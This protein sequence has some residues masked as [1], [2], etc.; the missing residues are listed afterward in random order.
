LTKAL[1]AEFDKLAQ[2]TGGA[3]THVTSDLLSN[4][5][6]AVRSLVRLP[7][8]VQ[9]PGWIEGPERPQ[10]DEFLAAQNGL[11]HVP[12]FL[13]G[14]ARY[15][16]PHSPAYFNT[17]SLEFAFDPKAGEPEEWMKFLNSLW[18]DEPDSIFLLQ[19]WCGYVLTPDTSQQKILLMVGPPRAGKG[20]I[21]RVIEA[22]VGSR[23]VAQPS[24]AGLTKQFGLQ[25]LIG[26]TVAVI[27]DAKTSNRMDLAQAAEKLLRISG[28]DGVEVDVK[29]QPQ[30]T[31]RLPIR[32]MILMNDLPD[33]P[34]ASTA[35]ANR[36]VILRFTRSWLG[37]EDID[38]E[39]RLR[40][41]LPSILLWSLKGLDRLRKKGRFTQPGA[42]EMTREILAGL[43]APVRQFVEDCCEVGPEFSVSVRDLFQWYQEWHQK[44]LGTEYRGDVRQFGR[45]LLAAVPTLGPAKQRK[46][47]GQ[48]VGRFYSGI[49]RRT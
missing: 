40:A 10:A 28:G 27:G 1:K 8:D 43:N 34:D 2:D 13:A 22:L 32:F 21:S 47:K 37:R 7:D 6:Q 44:V 3:A 18:P 15:L 33:F 31:L 23:N 38:L 14:K 9:Q 24:L 48:V 25:A 12:T 42:G 5:I 49:R 19:E 20:V 16:T 36:F 4:T 41:E 11:V 17:V 35:L 30:V 39:R 45:E 46:V 29:Y 26:K